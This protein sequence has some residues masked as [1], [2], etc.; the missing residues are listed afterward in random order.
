MG[1]LV[2]GTEGF[3]VAKIVVLNMEG[4]SVNASVELFVGE[5]VRLTLG[6]NVWFS[7]G[8]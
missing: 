4:F 3:W 5:E 2:G 8:K 7:F 6:E 1:S